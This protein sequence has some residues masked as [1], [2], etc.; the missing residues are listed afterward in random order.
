MKSIVVPVNYTGHAANAAR[1]AADLALSLGADIHLVYVF[2][3]PF[4][5]SEAPLP[6][7]AFEELE[8]SN[9][10]LLKDL[11]QELM[12]RASGLLNITT[13]I[14]VGSI[15]SRLEDFCK[16][17]DPLLV[18]MGASGDRLE[19]VLA[20]SNTVR[21]VR[22]LPYPILVVPEKARFHSIEK[23]VVACERED[24]V[25]GLPS[26]L[27]FLKELSEHLTG[28][29]L[30]VLHVLTDKE[31]NT[32]ELVIAYNDWKGEVSGLSPALHFIRHSKVGEGIEDYLKR[33]AADLVMVFPKKHSLLEFHKSQ[34]RQQV[35]HCAVPVM[36]VHE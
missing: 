31:E 8:L 11:K 27:P 22:H 34:A 1:Y 10:T 12:T 5:L 17:K 24:I 16:S 30:E 19:N 23:I 20:G 14:E 13:T 7:G 15:D 36:S 35:L 26:A 25:S 18:V 4:T 2:E 21:A 32:N 6:P 29:S 33:C 9:V 3:I 28:A